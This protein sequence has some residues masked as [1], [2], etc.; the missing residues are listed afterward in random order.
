[1]AKD[2]YDILGVSR[3][4]P[5]DEIK[6]AFR[7]LAHQHHPDKGGDSIKFKEINEAYQVLGNKERRAQYDQFGQ[8]FSGAGPGGFRWEDMA[9]GF[10]QGGFQ[11]ADFD[12]GDLFGDIFGFG[13]RRARTTRKQAGRDIELTLTI[14]FAEAAFGLTRTV[15]VEKAVPCPH[16]SGTGAEPSAGTSQCSSCGGSGRAEQVQQTILGSIRTVGVCPKCEGT[17]RVAKKVCE[18]CRGETIVH[19]AKTLEVTIPAGI[20]NGQTIRLAG[21]GEA[22]GRGAPAGDLYILVRVTPDPRFTREGANV[23][24]EATVAFSQAAL[25]A[26]VSVPTLEGDVEVK[27][28]SGTQSGRILRLKGKGAAKL[29]GHGRGD[30][31][32]TI[33]VQTPE[34]FTK[35]AKKILEDLREEGL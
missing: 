34:K 18:T 3:G 33:R 23:L 19:R 20:E 4:A 28:P 27:I 17:G 22:G 11:T 7:R 21:E 6:R 5:D 24:S 9:Q 26:M 35:R 2:Y 14:A 25:G 29:R 12:L 15:K 13:G 32:L 1:M 31:L 8:T 16:C 30:H 10:G